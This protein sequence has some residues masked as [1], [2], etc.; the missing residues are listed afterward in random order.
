MFFIDQNLEERVEYRSES[1][2]ENRIQEDMNPS[3]SQCLNWRDDEVQEDYFAQ[4]EVHQL[5]QES[6]ESNTV[7]FEIKE[8]QLSS[9]EN[10][11][12]VRKINK[13]GDQTSEN[14]VKSVDVEKDKRKGFFN[15]LKRRFGK[16]CRTRFVC[17]NVKRSFIEED[18]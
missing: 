1:C 13:S 2:I 7:Q 8:S 14:S 6:S 9:E 12:A 17:C 18:Y 10:S 15:K 11:V 3:I 4:N 5:E 16:F